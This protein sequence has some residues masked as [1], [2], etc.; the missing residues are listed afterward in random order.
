MA[1]SRRPRQ[2]SLAKAWRGRREKAGNHTS[3]TLPS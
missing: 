1:F 3:V 2:A